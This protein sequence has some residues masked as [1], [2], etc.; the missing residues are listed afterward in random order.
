MVLWQQVT[1]LPLL[2][3]CVL[4]TM[5]TNSR[6][7]TLQTPLEQAEQHKDT[8]NKYFKGKKY[9]S[10]LRCYEEAIKLCPSDQTVALATY[11]QNMAACY[12]L[13]V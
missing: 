5:E 12:E 1:V 3:L 9:D 8:G 10:A 13:M 11:H 4:V 7:N 2:R 6:Y